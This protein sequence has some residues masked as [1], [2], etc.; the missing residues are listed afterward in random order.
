MALNAVALLE[1]V[2]NSH[3]WK[4]GVT[5]PVRINRNDDDDVMARIMPYAS[6]CRFE[7]SLAFWL[8]QTAECFGKAL[9]PVSMPGPE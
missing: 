6:S 8:A 2:E 1:A 5:L 4:G 9:V 7:L 3:S